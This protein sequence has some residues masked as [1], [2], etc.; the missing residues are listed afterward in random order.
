MKTTGSKIDRATKSRIL[1]S[2]LSVL[3]GV[4]P[5]GLGLRAGAWHLAKEKERWTFLGTNFFWIEEKG[6][7]PIVGQDLLIVETDSG[8]M[9]F[10]DF[11]AKKL[12]EDL[13]I[14]PNK[15]P[16]K[17]DFNDILAAHPPFQKGR[18]RSMRS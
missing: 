5:V 16:P 17:F 15:L 12:A 11:L 9:P 14:P 6:L 4:A 7:I 2:A 8:P 10:Y 1:S 3:A 13:R 18:R